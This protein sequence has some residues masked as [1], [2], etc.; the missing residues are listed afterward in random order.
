[1]EVI[2]EV[3]LLPAL[4]IGVW[5][6]LSHIRKQKFLNEYMDLQRK[7]LEKGVA[8]PQDLKELISAKMNW[9]NVV[10]RIGIISLVLGIAG[11]LIIVYLIPGVPEI[12]KDKDAIAAFTGF[13]AIG[14]LLAAFGVGN[15][16][17]WFMIDKKRKGSRNRS[18]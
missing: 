4:L 2:M 8:L 7:A 18:E 6:I 3:L 11:V 14:Y 5:L 9:A 17:C 16:I 1:M 13:K 12:S 15:L 10:L